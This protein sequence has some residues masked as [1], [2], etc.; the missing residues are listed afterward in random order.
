MM[1]IN[2]EIQRPIPLL[3]SATLQKFLNTKHRKKCIGAYFF[4]SNFSI[5]LL[6]H[7]LLH[8]VVKEMLGYCSGIKWI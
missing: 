4:L 3:S 2:S 6:F 5:T 8:I 1:M 7:H